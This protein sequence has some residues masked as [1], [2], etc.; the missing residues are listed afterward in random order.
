M[1]MAALRQPISHVFTEQ[2]WLMGW[3]K[4][5]MFITLGKY[6]DEWRRTFRRSWENKGGSIV[7]D[8]S[9]NYYAVIDFY[10]QLLSVVHAKP[11]VILIGGPS[12]TTALVI[13]QARSLGYKGGLLLVEQAKM[14]SIANL[15]NGYK[16]IGDAIGIST[17]SDT[18]LPA[19]ASFDRKY[20][21]VYKRMSTWE[22]IWSYA[23]MFALARAVSIAGTV[24][25]IPAIR[26]AFPRTLPL[27]GENFS[28]EIHGMTVEGRLYVPVTTQVVRNGKPG[29]P[30]VYFWWIKSKDEFSQTKKL[31][32]Y[33]LPVN[34][35][36]P[37]D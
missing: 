37:V 32:K 23:S 18:L 16:L 4:A 27:L 36:N 12:A 3:R 9:A 30:S 8:K 2:A 35:L 21:G 31:S 24:E 26:S 13:E 28:C 33:K 19:S 5:A 34:W 17:V 1:N 22:A 10:D 20:T 11:D 6:G 14:D 29:K 25:Q 7:A 15:L